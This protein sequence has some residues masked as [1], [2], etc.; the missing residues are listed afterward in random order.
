MRRLL[1]VGVIIRV[2]VC[3]LVLVDLLGKLVLLLVDGLAILLGKLSVIHLAHVALFLIQRVFLFLQVA[4][5]VTSKLTALH[6]LM[7]PILLVL[8]ALTDGWL[9]V[10]TVGSGEACRCQHRRDG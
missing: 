8:F 6:A 7:N 3:W 1:C 5:L 4:R 9:L 10:I 2:Y